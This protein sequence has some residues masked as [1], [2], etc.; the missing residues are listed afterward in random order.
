MDAD[1]GQDMSQVSGEP[2]VKYL[3]RESLRTGPLGAGSQGVC[4]IHGGGRLLSQ[5]KDQQGLCVT[6]S[7]PLLRFSQLENPSRK[8]SSMKLVL[9]VKTESS[10]AKIQYKLVLFVGGGQVTS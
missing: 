4:S 7:G 10:L 3:H 6:I 2:L 8:I 5:R 9:S 1:E